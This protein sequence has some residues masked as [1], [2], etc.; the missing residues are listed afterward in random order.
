MLTPDIQWQNAQIK[1]LQETTG[2]HFNKQ[3]RLKAELDAVMRR[4]R[5]CPAGYNISKEFLYRSGIMGTGSGPSSAPT[6]GETTPTNYTTSASPSAPTTHGPHTVPP[7]LSGPPTSSVPPAGPYMAPPAT[8]MPPHMT[9]DNG[10]LMGG[11]GTPMV[12]GT[13]AVPPHNFNHNLNLNGPTAHASFGPHSHAHHPNFATHSHTPQHPIPSSAPTP[14]RP[15]PG[16]QLCLTR[17][18]YDSTMPAIGIGVGS[19]GVSLEV[20]PDLRNELMKNPAHFASRNEVPATLHHTTSDGSVVVQRMPEREGMDG[21]HAA[22]QHW[23]ITSAIIDGVLGLQGVEN[24]LKLEMAL[25]LIA[26]E[27]KAQQSASESGVGFPK[28]PP[29]RTRPET[30]RNGGD[31]SGQFGPTGGG[32]G[33]RGGGGYGGP[34]GPPMMSSYQPSGYPPSSMPW[35]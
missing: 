16:L 7:A 27:V 20:A 15:H 13:G 4:I 11:M 17:S 1:R 9:T 25:A 19:T 33:G 14:G 28:A 2:E 29:K 18:T 22:L 34:A 3:K 8:Q 30:P 10:A 23:R 6:T 24:N 21:S 35:G 31:R 32:R 26:A 5:D 12:P